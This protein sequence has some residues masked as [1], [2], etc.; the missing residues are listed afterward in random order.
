MPEDCINF[1]KGVLFET[2]NEKENG[3]RSA[4]GT[5]MTTLI[6]KGGFQKWPD[7]LGFMNKNLESHDMSAIE[8]TIE[9][10]AKI[11][12]DLRVNSE[13]YVYLDSSKGGSSLNVL[14]PRL[15][16]FCDISYGRKIQSV[17][18]H[19]LNLCI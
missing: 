17:A 7:L 5:L 12:E 16:I 9:C 18:I 13:N 11:V 10:I 8:N 6:Y 3:I 14:I 15:F 19:T 1:I 2:F 4:V